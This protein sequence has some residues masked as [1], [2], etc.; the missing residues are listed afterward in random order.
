MT[1]NEIR[2]L[3]TSLGLSAQR[4]AELI[5]VHFT[6]IYRWESAGD[7]KVNLE[8]L[9]AALLYRL[10]ERAAKAPRDVGERLLQGLLVGGTLLGLAYLLADL[11]EPETKPQR[12][13]PRRKSKERLMPRAKTPSSAHDIPRRCRAV[14]VNMIT[15]GKR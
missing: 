11:I 4:L 3:R 2:T 9:Q 5:G 7:R 6:S 1:G 8:P 14:G 12:A 10:Q 15:A 13:T